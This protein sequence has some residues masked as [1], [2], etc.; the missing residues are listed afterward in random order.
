MKLFLSFLTVETEI[1]TKHLG[2]SNGWTL[3]ENK[4]IKLKIHGGIVGGVVY[5]DAIEF[6]EKLSN[7]YNNY[8]NPFY[9]F[10]ILNDAGKSFFINYYKEE[11]N[12]LVKEQSDKVDYIKKSL[13]SESEKLINMESELNKLFSLLPKEVQNETN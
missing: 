9:I 11:I 10:E 1:S 3:R 6:G 4:S 2:Y 5:L 12:K 8:V 7:R 13:N